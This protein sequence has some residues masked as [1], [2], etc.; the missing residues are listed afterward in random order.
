MEKN[1][2]KNK[3][4][5]FIVLLS[6]IIVILG[7]IF[8]LIQKNSSKN[9]PTSIGLNIPKDNFICSNEEL[10]YSNV[11]GIIKNNTNNVYKNVTVS[12]I[13]YDGEGN[14]LGKIYDNIEF[15]GAYESWNFKAHSLDSTTNLSNSK[16]FTIEEIVGE[17]IEESEIITSDFNV[18]DISWGKGTHTSPNNDNWQG[19]YIES[20]V[21]NISTKDYN[22][23]FTIVYSVKSKSSGNKI[24]TYYHT[25]NNLKSNASTN[26]N[27]QKPYDKYAYVEIKYNRSSGLYFDSIYNVSLNC[28]IKGK[29]GE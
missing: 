25:I 27:T 22:E 26:C 15:L 2:K 17:K 3:I 24:C 7:V 14:T 5:I 8:F 21:K 13:L 20:N 12:C 10:K 11:T 4:I 29:L 16:S 28:I 18:Y 19:I 23:P 6:I 9:K 1:N